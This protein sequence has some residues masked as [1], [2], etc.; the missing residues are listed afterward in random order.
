MNAGLPVWRK[1]TFLLLFIAASIG[2]NGVQAQVRLGIVGGLHSSNILETNSLSGWDTAVK[3]YLSPKSG[4]QLGIIVEVPL[5]S[6]LYF[7]PALTYVTK[8]R[9][10][11]RN[12]D[13]IAALNT[14]TIYNKSSVNLSYIEIPQ[15]R[16]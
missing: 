8:G 12:N 15:A 4:F 1:I 7:Q 14:D 5:G 3:K 10:Y 13:S 6:G 16:M 2:G 11:S 9:Q